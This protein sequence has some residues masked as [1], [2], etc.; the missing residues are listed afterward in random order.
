LGLQRLG[1]Q[2]GTRFCTAF[3]RKLRGAPCTSTYF[4]QLVAFGVGAAVGVG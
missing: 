2:V 3:E 4:G 1:T